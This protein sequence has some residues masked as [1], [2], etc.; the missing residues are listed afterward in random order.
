MKFGL[1]DSVRVLKN[2]EVFDKGRKEWS[3]EIYKIEEIK[4]HILKVDGTWYKHYQIQK[5][6][7][8]TTDNDFRK[9]LDEQKR[10]HK[11]IRRLNKEGILNEGDVVS[12]RSKRERIIKFDKSLVGRRIDRGGSEK[13]TITKYESGGPYHWF[14]KYDTK[15]KMKSEWMDENE[16]KQF[17]IK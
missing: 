7:G 15:A 3:T 6:N 14:V 4:G 5:V 2:K 8:T 16:I 1:G 13:A 11:I 12:F 10:Q 17:L 9:H